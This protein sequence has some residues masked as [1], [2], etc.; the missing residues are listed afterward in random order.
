MRAGVPVG[1]VLTVSD[2]FDATG[3]RTS[4]DDNALLAA[5]ESMGA[6]AVAALGAAVTG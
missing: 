2:T 5:A 3:A 4:I 6:V 1:C